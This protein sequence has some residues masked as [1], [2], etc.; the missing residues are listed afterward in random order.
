MKKRS[1]DKKIHEFEEFLKKL[2]TSFKNSISENYLNEKIYFE[3]LIKQITNEADH[4]IKKIKKK[5]IDQVKN[6]TNTF[7]KINF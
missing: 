3:A 2:A 1:S 7:S 4:L 6:K 5:I